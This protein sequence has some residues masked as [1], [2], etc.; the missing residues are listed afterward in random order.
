MPTV[1]GAY[2]ARKLLTHEHAETFARPPRCGRC[3][4]SEIE[5]R[6]RKNGT[7]FWRCYTTA[8][9]TTPSG[10]TN[11]WTQEIRPATGH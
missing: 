4:G 11:A 8:C 3:K 5:I 7:W 2:F 1:R 10:R 9:K 6:R